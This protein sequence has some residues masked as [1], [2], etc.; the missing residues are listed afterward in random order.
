MRMRVVWLANTRPYMKF[1]IS[2]L[3]QVTQ[4][5]FTENAAAQIKRLNSSVRHAYDNIAHLPFPMLDVKSL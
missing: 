3:A 5:R 4:E 1:G 2:Q